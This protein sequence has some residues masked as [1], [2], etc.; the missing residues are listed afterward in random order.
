LAFLLCFFL[1]PFRGKHKPSDKT[2]KSV[3]EKYNKFIDDE[4]DVSCMMVATM[5][6]E[7]QK[8][9][10][11]RGAFD[12]MDQLKKM[13]QEK[14]QTKMCNLTK[15]LMKCSMRDNES[16]SSHMFKVTRYI[17]Q[18]EKLG[19]KWDSQLVT[20]IIFTS[21]SP[22]YSNF[23]M[24]YNMMGMSKRLDELLGLLKTDEE[25][26]NKG[27]GNV[28]AVNSAGKKIKKRS[29]NKSKGKSKGK[30]QVVTSSASKPKDVSIVEYL[31]CKK[32]GQ[33]KRNCPQFL[34]D[35]KNGNVPSSSSILIIEI[36]LAT[37]IS[38]WVLDT[39]SCAHVVQMCRH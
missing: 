8:R 15:A 6:S 35:K 27:S 14:A 29:K 39:D 17:E 12:I 24:N 38:D 30:A 21:L 11:T 10:K 28:L 25:D 9:F 5:S 13:L 19:C 16:V 36:K 32:R 1:R 18:L 22:H 37:S 3:R 33:W 7:L 34:E 23:I 4:L 26:M 20:N 2:E 31:Y